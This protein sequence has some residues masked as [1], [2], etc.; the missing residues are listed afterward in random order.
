MMPSTST[1]MPINFNLESRMTEM[2]QKYIPLIDLV[3]IGWVLAFGG[4]G[5]SGGGFFEILRTK[6]L[7]AWARVSGFVGLGA[8]SALG[9]FATLGVAGFLF[10]DGAVDMLRLAG[11]AAGAGFG[12][13]SFAVGANH[14]VLKQVESNASP[15][16]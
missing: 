4:V 10:G 5:G 13:V 14:L 1:T 16:K 8:V 3:L 2:P 7:P 12:A 9:A 11:M 6:T 15:K